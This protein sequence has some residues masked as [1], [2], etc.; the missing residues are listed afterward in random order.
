MSAESH[1]AV[2]RARLMDIATLLVVVATIT[3]AGVLVHREFFASTPPE[4]AHEKR[5]PVKVDNWEALSAVGHRMG[6]DAAEVTVVMWG[7]FECPACRSFVRST[8]PQFAAQ[9]SGKVALVYRH[10][11]LEQHRLSY[12]A[13]R[14]AE[15]AAEQGYFTQMHD[16]LY[17]QQSQLGAKSFHDIASEVGLRDMRAFDLCYA[18]KNP[19][20]AIERDT[21]A[22]KALGGVGT[23]TVLVNGWLL[24]DHID[25]RGLDS[26]TA[27]TR[28]SCSIHRAR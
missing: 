16:S 8:Y 21:R 12:P 24:R 4:P 10:W 9:Y 25:V 17:A 14:A 3:S 20:A 5:P 15:C 19:V 11:P 1:F 7:D 23:P 18:D 2:V 22:V 13:A 26:V 6:P 28:S 27:S